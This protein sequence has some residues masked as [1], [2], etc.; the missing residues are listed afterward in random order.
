MSNYPPRGPYMGGPPGGNPS[1][2]GYRPP[3]AGGGPPSFFNPGTGGPRTPPASGGMNAPNMPPPPN[4]GPPGAGPPGGSQFGGPPGPAPPSYGQPPSGPAPPSYGQPPAYG[5]PPMSAPGGGGGF[6]PPPS[7]GGPGGYGG[8]G[9]AAPAAPRVGFFNVSG[10]QPTQIQQQPGIAPPP[11]SS[12]NN[13][14][15]GPPGAGG[16]GMGGPPMGGPPG[17]M[18]GMGGMGMPPPPTAGGNPMGG[19]MPPPPGAGGMGM[20]GM[21]GMPGPPQYSA[22][23]GQAG[24]YPPNSMQGMPTGFDSGTN[25]NS[26]SRE[27]MTPGGHQQQP[28]QMGGMPGQMGGEMGGAPPLPTLDEVDLSIVCNPNF[29]RCSVSKIVSTQAQANASRLPLGVVCKP[30]AGDKGIIND[31]IEVVDFGATGIIRCKR[32]RTYI[33]P[34]VTWADNG[35]RWRCN[36]CGMLNDVPST[37]FSHLDAKGHRRDRDQRPELTKCSIEF[38]APGDYMVRPPQPPVFFFVIDVSEPSVS[39]GMIQSAVNAIKRSLD[40]LPGSPRTQVGFITF[41]HQIHF[42]NLKSSLKSPQMLIVSDIHDVIIPLPDDLLVNLQESRSVVDSF[43]EALPTMFKSN[44]M[45]QSCTG[46]ALMAA[47]RV[48]QHVGGKLLLFQST[49]PSLGEGALKMRENPRLLGTDKE[50]TLLN[51]EDPWY[52]TNSVDFSRLQV[53]VDTFL[54]SA[55]YTDLATIAVLSKYSGGST[56]YYP[57]FYGA[58]DGTKFEKE[59]CKCLVRATAFE[60]VMRIRATRGLRFSNFYG[61]YFIRGTDLLALPNCTADST[62]ALDLAYDEPTLP[63]QVITI[64]AALLYTNSVGDRRIRVHTMLLPVTTVS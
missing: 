6:G 54:F 17:S 20:P 31:D 22:A 55:Q 48:I 8:P 32:C 63:A 52:K 57:G 60:A 21:G 29:L 15:P 34:Y 43:L 38:V 59:L 53:C 58:R 16:M 1:Q 44:T 30:L 23:Y 7:G 26:L 35:R 10:G 25:L 56:Y 11:S 50:H 14:M 19:G 64:Q 12:G 51:A 18:G 9:P 2:P 3:G 27:G 39:S 5:G 40:D 37:Y 45:S 61:N 46:P 28:G 41:D 33:N 49:L 36:I 47:K 13:F 42:Y 62:F 24:A 4:Y